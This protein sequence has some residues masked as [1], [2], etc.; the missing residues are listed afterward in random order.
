ML[1]DLLALRKRKL[2]DC[3]LRVRLLDDNARPLAPVDEKYTLLG[4][5]IDETFLVRLRGESGA[6]FQSRRLP[7]SSAKVRVTPQSSTGPLHDLSTPLQQDEMLNFHAIPPFDRSAPGGFTSAKP[8][9]G[10]RFGSLRKV[11]PADVVVHKRSKEEKGTNRPRGV[12]DTGYVNVDHPPSSPSDERRKAKSI[13]GVENIQPPGSSPTT[14]SPVKTAQARR[15]A[16]QPRKAVWISARDGSP[17]SPVTNDQPSY[18]A[19][20]RGSDSGILDDMRPVFPD[21]ERSST[22]SGKRQGNVDEDSRVSKSSNVSLPDHLHIASS[23]DS[24][25]P[26]PKPRSKP[27]RTP[28]YKCDDSSGDEGYSYV[29]DFTR[30]TGQQPLPGHGS[31]SPSAQRKHSAA[32]TQ[33]PFHQ[34]QYG[35]G[36]PEMDLDDMVANPQYVSSR[37][38]NA[39]SKLASSQYSLGS[40]VDEDGYARLK[41]D[42]L[43]K[44]LEQASA[45]DGSDA[46]AGYDDG[47]YIQ[48]KMRL[49]RLST[50]NSQASSNPEEN[51]LYWKYKCL[52]LEEELKDAQED[53]KQLTGGGASDQK[54]E[55]A[56]ACQVWEKKYQEMADKLARSEAAREI[57]QTKLSKLGEN[58][59]ARWLEGMDVDEVCE[60]LEQLPPL[61]QYK[62]VFKREAVTGGDLLLLEDEMLRDAFGIVNSYHRAKLLNEIKKKVNGAGWTYSVCFCFSL[63]QLKTVDVDTARVF[64]PTQLCK[65]CLI[66]LYIYATF[67]WTQT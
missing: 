36:V 32:D 59:T 18:P 64:F 41:P 33:L 1:A 26:Q 49:E 44:L 35:N 54:P 51:L 15:M 46:G 61:G 21:Y 40:S 45:A 10:V 22:W 67:K 13:A 60:M 17:S 7:A 34:L 48:M 4:S 27:G 3:P 50:R 6:A 66:S 63:S 11:T 9:G 31:S 30:Y 65:L 19:G 37:P 62:E 39:T 28:E 24:R 5:T 53:V 12:S 52:Q 57:A 29:A 42:L 14:V 56:N 47:S 16:R 2:I 8:K 20:R 55:V 25:A 38:A 43:L 58:P 23:I